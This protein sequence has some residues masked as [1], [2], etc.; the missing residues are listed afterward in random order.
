M[1]GLDKRSIGNFILKGC[2][3][4]LPLLCLFLLPYTRPGE[5]A[6]SAWIDLLFTIRG[7]SLPPEN[8]VIVAIDEP[9]FREIGLQWPW[10]RALHAQLVDGLKEAGAKVI[11]FD[12]MFVEESRTPSDD[13]IFASSIKRAGNVVLGA[14]ISQIHRKNYMEMIFSEPVKI[15]KEAGAVAGI[16]NF[17]PDNDGI[18]RHGRLIVNNLP[19]L[20]MAASMFA[21]E[22]QTADMVSE[23][24]DYP[25][26]IDFAG[27]SGTLKTVSYYQALDRK[28]YLPQ[29]IFKDKIVLVG[30]SSDAAV[31][32]FRGAVD[33]FPT[34]F[35]RFSRKAM[36]GIEIHANTITTILNGIPLREVESP[37]L[38]LLFALL[39]IFPFFIRNHPFRLAGTTL[40]ITALLVSCSIFMFVYEKQVIAIAAPVTGVIAAS[41]WWGISG[42]WTTFMERRKIRLAF[43][44][45]VP[46][47]VVDEAIK[48]P[49]QLHLGGQQAELTVLFSDIRGFT[50]LS[51]KFP[52][53]TLVEVLNYYLDIMTEQVFAH[54]GL[55][56]KYIGDAIMAV[57]G[58]PIPL[59]NHAASACRTAL[60]MTSMLDEV[61]NMWQRYNIPGPDI[62][63]GIN[64]GKMLVGNMGS[65]KRF[66]YTVI[67][68]EVN[69]A[70]RL[71]GL[72]KQYGTAIIIGENTQ[73]LLDKSFVCRELDMVRVKG[74]LKPIKIFEVIMEGKPDGKTAEAIGLFQEAL[75]LYR[76]GRWN[77]AISTFKNVLEIRHKDPPSL[78]F[79]KRCEIMLD[80]EPD[81]WDGIWTMKTK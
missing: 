59:E 11:A 38:E 37:L 47:A 19:T 2:G 43:D 48:N 63:I 40:I 4:I 71:E 76:S 80:Q 35:F 31:E 30:L 13:E 34:P 39:V 44:K 32:I 78:T 10:P 24:G 55:L 68:D 69:L 1:P 79:I 16:V 49:E 57:F 73:K 6:D 75:E 18:I 60:L 5:I 67:G 41:L 61:R 22:Q 8:I 27:P 33:T 15:L 58:A 50:S 65:S 66:D 56:D 64:S 17:F 42:Y 74:K 7:N 25:F 14:G 3:L 26:L 36:F 81:E 46:P 72:N 21:N 28:K 70:S 53:E 62:G 77:D 54:N 20:A 52:P 29:G 12:V 45:Y 9:S 51:E 23:Y